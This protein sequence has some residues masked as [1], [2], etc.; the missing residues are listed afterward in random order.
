MYTDCKQSSCLLI[1]SI[2][3]K[4]ERLISELAASATNGNTRKEV[5]FIKT[6]EQVNQTEDIETWTAK[7]LTRLGR[8]ASKWQLFATSAEKDVFLFRNPQKKL[9]LTVY[10]RPNGER[11]VGQVWGD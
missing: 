2:I 4:S 11:V 8:D 1:I 6:T 9:Q 10:Q 3:I 7:E 5:T